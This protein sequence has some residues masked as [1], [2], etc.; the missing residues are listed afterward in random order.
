MTLVFFNFAR[1]QKNCLLVFAKEPLPGKVKTRLAQKLGENKACEI[2]VSFLKIIG[3]EWIGNFEQICFVGKQENITNTSAQPLDLK[4]L[5]PKAVSFPEQESGDL[6]NKIYRAFTWAHEAG[7]EKIVIVGSDS[8]DLPHSILEKAFE[9]L[10]TASTVIG[11][12]HDGGYYL[13]GCKGIPPK[14]LFE[15]INWSTE[16]VF[17]DTVKKIKEQQLSCDVLPL[18]W[19]IDTHEDYQLYLKRRISG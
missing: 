1:M 18:W 14:S 12:T 7:Y 13:I 15:K 19:D 11:P 16:S 8:P 2:Y 9:L 6:G 5:F 3:S 10:E 17:N 4:P